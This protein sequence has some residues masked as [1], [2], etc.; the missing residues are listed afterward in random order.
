MSIIVFPID[1]YADLKPLLETINST[2]T[3]TEKG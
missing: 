3:L 2:E 1:C